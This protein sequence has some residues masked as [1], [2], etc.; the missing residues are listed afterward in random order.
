MSK[1]IENLFIG[2]KKDPH[3]SNWDLI[4]N[5]TPHLPFPS[6]CQNT[7]RI[8]VE[9]DPFDSIKLFN[10]IKDTNTLEVIHQ[11]LSNNKKVLVHCQQG[12]QRSPTVVACYLLKYHNYT[13]QEAIDFIK[14]KR[15]IAFFWQLNLERTL[16]LYYDFLQNM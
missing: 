15:T 11:N 2:N 7:I 13:K 12:V 6:T 16:D 14:L 10:L 1:I 8:P 9:D 4:V 5:C 3:Y